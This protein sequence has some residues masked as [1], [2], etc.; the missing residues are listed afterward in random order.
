[1]GWG[2]CWGYT[3]FEMLL[4]VVAD[5]GGEADFLEVL[6]GHFK[7]FVQVGHMLVD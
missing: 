6:G 1:M 7:Q 5:F 3:Y 2:E 4:D